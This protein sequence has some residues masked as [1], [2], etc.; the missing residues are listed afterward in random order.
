M[1]RKAAA[2]VQSM[3]QYNTKEKRRDGKGYH[4]RE[5][6]KGRGGE[7]EEKEEKRKKERKEKLGCVVLIF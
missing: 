3:I 4:R 1:Q 5:K 7:G 6:E 2:F